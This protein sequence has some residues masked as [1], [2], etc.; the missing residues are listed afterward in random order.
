[1]PL[2]RA[3]ACWAAAALLLV[4][5]GGSDE[6]RKALAP[7]ALTVATGSQGGIYAVW[8]AAYA[9][10]ITKQLEGYRG[11]ATRTTGSV[12]NLERLR[13]GR[14]QIALTLGDTA[15]DA[16]EGREA[17]DR[18]VALKALAQIYP[19]YVQLVTRAGSGIGTLSDLAGK[20]VSVG[21]PDSGT[22]V[23]A[24]R[25]LDVAKVGGFKRE[26]LGIAESATA[27]DQRKLDAFFWSGGVP[28]AAVAELAKR[29]PIGVVGLGRYA[30]EMQIRWGGVY[31]RGSLPA[32]AYG[33][34][35][36]VTTITI[37][38]YVVVGDRMDA[39]LAHDLTSL[40]FSSGRVTDRER[41]QDVIAEIGLHPGSQ[42]YFSGG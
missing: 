26:Q 32:G 40:L 24:E 37:P 12:E 30:R 42:A 3:L 29:T 8:G 25:V 16:V 13:D 15:L 39:A 31:D 33:L 36:R 6:P 28:T 35:E 4:G 11:V 20:R 27:L 22:Q 19:S 7:Q 23:V 14:A 9:R 38:N 21:S 2:R 41:A 18:P 10:A 34:S 5:C 17:F 1:M